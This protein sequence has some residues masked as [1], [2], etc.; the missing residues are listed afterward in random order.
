[1]HQRRAM[2]TRRLVHIGGGHHGGDAALADQGGEDLPEITAR[3][4][5]DTGRGLIEDDQVGL[6][7]QGA[8]QA[9]LLLHAPGELFHGP[10]AERLQA[11]QAEQPR[12]ALGQGRIGH[13]THARQK[14]DVFLDRQVGI[15]VLTQPL[16][17]EA[18]PGLDALGIGVA[19]NAL[20]QHAKPPLIEGHHPGDRLEQAALA[21]PVGAD[22]PEQIPRRAI[23]I[24]AAHGLHRAVGLAQPLDLDRRR[25]PRHHCGGSQATSSRQRITASAGNPGVRRPCGFSVT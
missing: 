22:E 15:E 1:M 14:I 25:R 21:R 12:L 5:I 24:D 17:H 19:V 2:E 7:D 4:R 20:A 16:G 23:E 13:L 11:G 3:D 9:Q 8:D 18:E 6:V 10:A